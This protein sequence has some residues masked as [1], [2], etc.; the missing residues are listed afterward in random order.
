MFLRCTD[1]NK[2]DTVLQCF[3]SGVERY[4]VPN[5]VRSDKGLENVGV[6]DYMLSKKSLGGH[7]NRKKHTQPKDLNR[8]LR[9]V[10][11]GVRA[12]FYNLFHY[13]EDQGILEPLN[14]THLAALHYVFIAEINRRLSFW[15]DAWTG[16]ILRAV[17]S[18]PFNLWTSG[19]LQNPVGLEGAEYLQN[20]GTEGL[21]D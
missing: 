14:Q 21:L 1:N 20:Y 2:S 17:K 16:H 7:A 13:M 19:Q 3:L 11:D 18:S 10:N 5:R 4:G 12:F 15:S 6:A 9:D 8:L